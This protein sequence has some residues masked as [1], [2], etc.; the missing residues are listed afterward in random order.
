[1]QTKN[2]VTINTVDSNKTAL[3]KK[4][5]SAVQR[6]VI[7]LTGYEPHIYSN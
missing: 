7:T 3:I 5:K 1:M 6:S 4:T 2:T